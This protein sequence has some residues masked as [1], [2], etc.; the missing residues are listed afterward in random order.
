M[1]HK[2]IKPEVEKHAGWTRWIK[3]YMRG[4]LIGCCDC[5]L[6]HWMDFRIQRG[7][8]FFRAKRAPAYTRRERKRHHKGSSE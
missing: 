2:R 7:R 8:V 1:K 5:G 3:P 6:H 4:Y